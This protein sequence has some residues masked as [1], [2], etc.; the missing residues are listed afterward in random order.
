MKS[1]VSLS[2]S[3]KMEALSK[4]ITTASSVGRSLSQLCAF[5]LVALGLVGFLPSLGP[6]PLLEG[7]ALVL[8]GCSLAVKDKT[9]SI[10]AALAVLFISGLPLIT[11]SRHLPGLE[12][13]LLLSLLS[14]AVY[15]SKRSGTRRIQSIFLFLLI[16]LV[17]SF[18]CFSFLG[19]LEGV[20]LGWRWLGGGLAPVSA[21]ALLAG[22]MSIGL[23][24]I[25]DEV[26]EVGENPQEILRSAAVH[27][28]VFDICAA[29]IA[30]AAVALPLGSTLVAGAD[31]GIA[32]ASGTLISYAL[33]ATT[34]IVVLSL[35]F[36]ALLARLFIHAQRLQGLVLSQR[37][38]LE[39]ERDELDR[40]S[41]TLR[42]TSMKRDALFSHTPD[43]IITFR[44]DGKIES[45]NP[46][47]RRM[48]GVDDGEEK[49]LLVELLP[50]LEGEAV[51]RREE[52]FLRSDGRSFPLLA[53]HH[54]GYFFPV[55]VALS[56]LSV[57]GE[58]MT[59]A[60]IRDITD[61]RQSEDRMKQSLIEK[62]TLIKEIHHRVKNNLQVISSLLSLQA[63]K[64]ESPETRTAILESQN[65]VRSMALLHELLYQSADFSSIDFKHYV[66]KLSLNLLSSYGALDRIRIKVEGE[67]LFLDLDV[68][69]ALGI[70]V[71]ELVSNSIRHGFSGI[72][73]LEDEPEIAI[74]MHDDDGNVTFSVKDNGSGI[75]GDANKAQRTTLGLKLVT[76]LSRQIDAVPEISTEGGTSVTI[77]FWNTLT[78]NSLKDRVEQHGAGSNI[79]R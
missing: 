17:I 27:L 26:H 54:E 2:I 61:R 62:E 29:L 46:A 13:A 12:A 8:L 69:I 66:E 47:A 57:G 75:L 33:L 71:N 20:E 25:R 56:S 16:V 11:T 14:A 58:K 38:K 52:E 39:S 15:L 32:A 68:A 31:K 19:H 18:A 50:T 60:F 42:E 79:G 55:E 44:T 77:K 49:Q 76:N 10:G 65:R 78:V 22:G 3:P 36:I 48:F 28:L 63:R 73:N 5:T 53:K 41:K 1:A 21:L 64:I 9:V 34:L 40:L 74:S 45:L 4:V 51:S 23:R 72:D 30:G 70:I 7:I 35:G 24:A 59:I 67:P 6:L 37:E 43:G